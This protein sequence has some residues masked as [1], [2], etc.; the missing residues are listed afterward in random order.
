MRNRP[1]LLVLNQYYWPGVEATANLL[2]ELCEALAETHDVTVIA[3]TA[4]AVPAREIRN[5]VCI[6]RVRSTTFDR[7]RIF[8]RA[9]NYATYVAGLVRRAMMSRRPDLVV[10]MT[11]PP[12]VGS[13][14]RLVAARFRV[15]L[16][17]VMQD[18]FPEIAVRLGRLRS[19]ASARLLRLLIDPSLRAADRV[20]VIGE[21]MKRRVEAKGVRSERIRVIPNWG[22]VTSVVPM[23][24]D[25]EWS[26]RHKL[27]KR[28]V[29]MHSGN[30]GHAQNLDALVRATTFLRDLDDLAVV[31][32]GSGARRAE[33]IGLARAL[34]A[35]KV[36]ILPYQERAILSQSLSTADLHVVGLAKGLAGYV[37]PS[38]LY[39]ILAA[40]R[41]VIAAT[42]AESETAQLVLEVGCGVLVPPGNP[43]ALAAAIRSAHDGEYDLAEMGRRGREWVEREA[44]RSVAVRR[45]REL[46]GE[47]AP[48]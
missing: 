17:I 45:Y 14:A 18:V 21:T 16:L 34:E 24:H 39:G 4:R 48:S 36:E 40:G 29:V 11:D 47:L 38:R 28:F 22:D 15:P 6:V 26:R 33:L 23:P 27:V 13:I 42:D 1:R 9:A 35:D 3:G 31:I 32:I 5:G 44:D 2:T 20:V 19:P 43:F 12:F 7:S 8:G 41:P 30:I 25:N 46:L 10:S 37:V